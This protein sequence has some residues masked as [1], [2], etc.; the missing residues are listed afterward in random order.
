MKPTALYLGRFQPFH[1]GH[2]WVIR[3]ALQKY[4]VKIAIGSS[5]ENSAQNPFTKEERLEMIRNTL[6]A[7]GLT[8]EDI[9][10]VPDIPND[11]EYVAHVRRIC[12]DFDLT[13]GGE[14]DFTRDLFERAGVAV[15]L[16]GRFEGITATEVRRRMGVGEDWE[17]LVPEGTRLVI[18]KVGGVERVRLL[19]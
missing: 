10:F 18:E 4:K 5:E 8:V 17:V 6:K 13:L 16:E 12:G 7:D 15:E 1:L 3:N 19:P 11:D 2:L 9:Y 14:K